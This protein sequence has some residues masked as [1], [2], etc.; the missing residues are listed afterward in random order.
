[1]PSGVDAEAFV[2]RWRAKQLEY[3]WTST[4]MRRRTT[5]E[6]LGELALDWT[7]TT[8]RV[9]DPHARSALLRAY[10]ELPPYV[11]AA[12]CLSRLRARGLR[13]AVLSNGSEATI[14]RVLDRSGLAPFVDDVLSV[15]RVGA[16]KPDP[17]V[18]RFAVQMLGV[19]PAE[20]AFQTANAWDAAGATAAG[21]GV[22]WIE[23][24]GAADE[25]GLRG[26]VREVSSL[27]ALAHALGRG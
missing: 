16:F 8:Y 21:F 26:R 12:Q 13:I 15:E 14:E 1:V 3:S 23:R 9:A 20:I 5:F 10:C 11:D 22:H 24:T 17:S 27:G 2:D 4:V 7:L 18:Y 25:Y 6:L 19:R